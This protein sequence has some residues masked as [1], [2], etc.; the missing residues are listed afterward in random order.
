[1]VLLCLKIFVEVFQVFGIYCLLKNEEQMY[2]DDMEAIWSM[3]LGMD[4]TRGLYILADLNWR[5]CSLAACWHVFPPASIFLYNATPPIRNPM[6]SHI[7]MIFSLRSC[8][9]EL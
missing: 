6:G 1:M 7:A 4:E 8:S 3:H 2:V 5:L 9:E